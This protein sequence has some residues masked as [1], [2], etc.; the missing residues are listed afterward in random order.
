MLCLAT[1]YFATHVQWLGDTIDVSGRYP[2]MYDYSK[3]KLSIDADTATGGV[4]LIHIDNT[5]I[6]R[7]RTAIKIYGYDVYGILPK[8][9][10]SEA[11]YI[12][13]VIAK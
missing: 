6:S 2:T 3:P 10:G 11:P 13:F 7:N 4:N 5:E 8:I 1:W 12:F 9:I